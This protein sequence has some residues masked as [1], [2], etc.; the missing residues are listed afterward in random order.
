MGGGT[1]AGGIAMG[2][3]AGAGEEGGGV[4]GDAA[5]ATIAGGPITRVNSPGSA[6]NLGGTADVLGG[7]C[8]GVCRG[9][10]LSVKDSGGEICADC[11]LVPRGAAPPKIRVNSPGAF[12]DGE[13]TGNGSREASDDGASGLRNSLVNSPG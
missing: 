6:G 3:G 11:G 5:G 10:K 4:A 13:P 2:S 12:C 9:S 1:G 7:I 8:D